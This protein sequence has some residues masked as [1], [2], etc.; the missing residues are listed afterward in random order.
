MRA[1]GDEVNIPDNNFLQAKTMP[2]MNLEKI[3]GLFGNVASRNNFLTLCKA[4]FHERVREEAAETAG[5]P[6]ASSRRAEFHNETM[7]IVQKL[8]LRSSE[9]MPSRKDVGI[10]IMEHFR[11]N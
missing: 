11:E 8:F 4:Y 9:R 3:L 2:T 7:E 1:V 10:M 6:L 5:E